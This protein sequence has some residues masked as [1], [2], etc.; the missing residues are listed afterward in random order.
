[1]PKKKDKTPKESSELS[2]IEIVTENKM[3]NNKKKIKKKK[4]NNYHKPGQYVDY[5]I[6]LF[7]IYI[8]SVKILTVLTD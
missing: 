4:I 7:Q 3:K 5:K 1:M 8:L 6:K 2:T